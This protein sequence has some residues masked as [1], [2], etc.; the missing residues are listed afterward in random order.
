MLRNGDFSL[1]WNGNHWC[2]V[3]ETD[4]S[5]YRREAGEIRVADGWEGAW[6]LHG[7]PV[8]HDNE[9]TV[10]YSAPEA[11]C[12]DAAS[13]ARFRGAKP[14]Y[15]MFTFS[16]AHHCGLYQIVSNIKTGSTIK[17]SG[18]A[19]AWSND[20]NK[21]RT[22]DPR[23][24][25]GPGYGPG[26]KLEGTDD[27]KLWRNFTFQLGID[28]TGGVD[29][30]ADTV[31]W[32]QG[33]HIYNEFG[34]VPEVSVV[35][36]GDS[37]TVFISS[38]ALWP[39]K[40][41]D[42]YWDDIVLTAVS[43]PD[44]PPPPDPI[45]VPVVGTGSKIGIH[46]IWS[47]S[48]VRTVDALA[49]S[50]APMCVVKAVDDL[51]YLRDSKEAGAITIARLTSR[52]EGVGGCTTGGDPR[53]MAAE[54][55]SVIEPKLDI[56]GPYVDY[57]EICNEP[58]GGGCTPEQYACLAETMK[59]CM[60]RADKLGIQL[61]LFAF[62]AGTPEW[63][64]MVAMVDTGVFEIAYHGGHI[65]TSHEGALHDN[66]IDYLHGDLIPGA[67]HVPAGAG[68]MCGRFAY[69]FEAIGEHCP[70]IV[71]SEFYGHYDHTAAS[72]FMWYDDLVKD[73]PQV[74]GF[75]GFTWGP[76]PAWKDQDYGPLTDWMI[77][78]NIEVKDRQNATY[79]P[80]EP[81]ECRGGAREH[82]DRVYHCMNPAFVSD[83]DM[84]RIWTE[85]VMGKDYVT[86]GPS[87][88]DAMLHC[89]LDGCTA[90]LY[91]IPEGVQQDYIEFRD[92]YYPDAF[93]IF[94]ST[95]ELP[96]GTVPIVGIHDEAGADYLISRGV[97]NTVLLH[98]AVVRD[99]ATGIDMRRH[100]NSYNIVRLNWGYHPD[101]TMPEPRY[102]GAHLDAL[103]GTINRSMGVDL[104]QLW[105][106]PNNAA[107]WPQGFELTPEYVT[108]AYNYVYDRVTDH[109]LAPPP[110][111]PYYGPGSNNAD[112]TEFMFENIH[113]A[114]A[115]ITHSG[116]SQVCDPAT[117]WSS[118][119]FRHEPLTWQYL[120]S[121]TLYTYL[122]QVPD[123]FSSLPIIA[124]EANPQHQTVIGGDVGWLPS[125]ADEWASEFYSFVIQT[126][127]RP[128]SPQVTHIVYYRWDHDPWA[129]R[130]IPA[131][132]DR[133][134][135]VAYDQ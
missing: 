56:H 48:V 34:P 110:I 126:N 97:T 69:L 26:Y 74:L 32:G 8:P 133:I 70:P 47:D 89:G 10:G 17:L 50:N 16:R 125:L 103:V 28:P 31:V 42:A 1:P 100:R 64:D 117:I 2:D 105:N 27:S 33:A 127:Q 107:E 54:L 123:R 5:H 85:H 46:S 18:Y 9:N 120:N 76:T 80:V 44:P 122:A 112:W 124:G 57:W 87:F 53:Q 82:F 92:K 96:V 118:I 113:G 20:W 130:D 131:V 38:K 121:K 106:E 115:L 36:Q 84:I 134:V 43:D 22:D 104:F 19:H 129:L 7:L 78:H 86:A 58:L 90:Y 114:G 91:N 111:D 109:L 37:V 99:V 23:W 93:I 49:S 67:P 73:F 66:P 60:E 135:E 132:L 65:I 24:S 62:N 102:L 45:V 71:I 55:M 4:G 25:E 101:G 30:F 35:A 11:R 79:K 63:A 75:C 51:A 15:M 52:Y 68:A 81:T 116:K 72:N 98:P 41:N 3:Y 77:E 88:D 12:T 59:C 83:A 39:Y 61:A 128:N 108:A 119:K 29:P 95:A 6:Y 14:G 94:R 40:H 13:P 21:P